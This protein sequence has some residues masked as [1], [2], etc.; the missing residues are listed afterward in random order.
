LLTLAEG[1][2]GVGVDEYIQLGVHQVYINDEA[3]GEVFACSEH[4]FQHV[5]NVLF[6]WGS[7]LNRS[8]HP[9]SAPENTF[10]TDTKKRES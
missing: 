3:V 8:L 6:H 7:T 10:G 4:F 1:H 2:L 9:A 5:G